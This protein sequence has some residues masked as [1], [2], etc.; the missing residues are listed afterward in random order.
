[1]TSE[2]LAARL[3]AWPGAAIAPRQRARSA[4][5]CADLRATA[6]L[7]DPLQ[8]PLRAPLLRAQQGLGETVQKVPGDRSAMA[9][10]R[11]GCSKA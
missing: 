8:K 11:S 9:G 1:M 6:A 7:D 10:C 5:G 4:A 3:A 2:T